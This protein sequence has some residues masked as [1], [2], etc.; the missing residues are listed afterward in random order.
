MLS[1]GTTPQVLEESADRSWRRIR[2]R[3]DGVRNR[4]RAKYLGTGLLAALAVFVAAFL[5]FSAAD[6]VFKLAVGT[7]VFVLL[8]TVI[9]VAFSLF[10]FVYRPWRKLG[11][12]IQSAREVEGVY[13]Q[14]EQQLSTALEFGAD[15]EKAR[16]FASPLL[17]AALVNQAGERS[18]PLDF[19][20]TIRWKQL[21]CAFGIAFVLAALMALYAAKNSRLFAITWARFMKP[22]AN[23]AAPTLT[24]IKNVYPGNDK[25]EIESSVEIKVQLDGKLPETATLSVLIGDEKESHWEDRPMDRAEDGLYKATLRRLLDTARYKIHAG[26]TESDEYRIKVYKKPEIT[27]FALRIEHPAYTGKGIEA[28]PPGTGDVRALRGSKIHVDVKSNVDLGRASI[29]FKS[30]RAEVPGSFE[31]A[32][33]RKASI[34]FDVD[35]D[36]DYQVKIADADGNPGAGALFQIKALKDRY[37]TVRIKKP[38]KDLMVHKEQTVEV[39]IS[40]DDD[41][42]VREI[43]IFHSL[44]MEEKQLMVRRLDP[45]PLH[46][47]GK[48]V[49]ELGQ[50]DLKGGEVISYYAYAMD[51]DTVTAGGPKMSKSDIHFITVYDEEKYD[52]EKD[53]KKK[54]KKQQGTPPEIKQLDKLIDAQKKILKDDFAQ[55]RQHESL[56]DKEEADRAKAADGEKV[57]ASKTNEGQAQ[58][59]ARVEKLIDEVKKELEQAANPEAEAKPKEGDPQPGGEQHKPALG[60]KEMK[61]ME[62]AIVKMALAEAE[63]KKPDTPAAVKPMNE[64]LRHLSET[65]RLLLSDKEGDPRFKMAMNKNSKKNQKKDQEQQQQDQQQAKEQLTQMPPMMER[66]KE[67]DRQ[68]EELNEK[69]QQPPQGDPQSEERKQQEEQKRE[70]Q[71][72]AEDAAE[73]LAKEAEDRARKL[74]D[75]AD[76][77][78]DLKPAQDKMQQAADKAKQAQNELKQPNQP[79]SLENAKDQNRQAQQNSREA[80]RALEQA[81]QKQTRQQ[82]DNAQK[83]AEELANRQ[84]DIAEKMQQAQNEQQKGQQKN[85]QNAEKKEG[86]PQSAKNEQQQNGEQKSGEKQSAQQ[87]N[88]QQPQKGEQQSAQQQGGEPKKGE[89]Q[90]AQ[91]QGGESK[92]GEQTAQQQGQGGQ[93]SAEQTMREQAAKQAD[94]KNDLAALNETLKS[95]GDKAQEEGLGGANDIEQA[96]RQS[97]ENSPANQAADKAAQAMSSGK[98]DEAA[99]EAK[100][101][102][103]ALQQLAEKLQQAKQN[104]DAGDMKQMAAAMKKLQAAQ[105]EQGDIGK[106]LA[107]KDKHNAPDLPNRQD[108]VDRKS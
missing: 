7:R 26:D 52:N 3:V 19:K 69:K 16:K 20:R 97:N 14:L 105:K 28:L 73:K 56:R 61:H 108:K 46:V 103:K 32:E 6:I 62:D 83:Q 95:L 79:R 63:L 39:E 72:K 47:D 71:K 2:S 92:K 22:T 74:E 77:N 5:G 33:A 84:Q 75:L 89:Q 54:D 18:E 42:G 48:L 57:A 64:A 40:A 93:P 53:P 88:G 8:S 44:G 15:K 34:V 82:L 37:P 51:N 58:L 70:L 101:A 91:Q 10:H 23:I 104:T 17:V 60:E 24:E 87:Q 30:K 9:A 43:G 35:K 96:K 41:I 55:A 76:R 4:Q 59:R 67:L 78:D 100:N 65:R 99:R 94:V 81:L 106:D 98:Q 86:Q 1:T 45:T 13:P 21:A 85:E 31:S 11:N 12:T 68:L 27:E 38:E 29:A 49:W 102:E 107:D 50:M 36:D 66:Q 90:S 25:A 80:K